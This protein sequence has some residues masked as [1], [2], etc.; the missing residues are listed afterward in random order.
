MSDPSFHSE[1]ER[2]L[3]ELEAE[4]VQRIHGNEASTESPQMNSAV[5][6]LT[7]IDAYQ[8]EQM[9]L[10]ARRQLQAR[11]STVREAL[12]RVRAG[13]YGSCTRCGGSIT[14][15]RLEYV[16]ETPFCTGCG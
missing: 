7:Y 1:A 6:R 11:L 13:T 14:Q 12:Q 16:P 4:I 5:G 15:E 10:H 9:S 2:T 3:R 8:Q